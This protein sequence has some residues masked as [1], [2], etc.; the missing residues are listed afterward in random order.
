[1]ILS[2]LIA[3]FFPGLDGLPPAWMIQIVIAILVVIWLAWDTIHSLYGKLSTS[4]TREITEH[5][6]EVERGLGGPDGSSRTS[7]P[8]EPPSR[9]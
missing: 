5:S 1:M 3:Q 6:A 9:H 7:G 8:D 2:L 4:L